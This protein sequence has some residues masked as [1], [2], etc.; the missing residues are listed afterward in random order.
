MLHEVIL[1]GREEGLGDL[2]I[3]DGEG[4]CTREGGS[5]IVSAET[6]IVRGGAS[7][8]FVW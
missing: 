3:R 8:A 7:G 6:S 5:D 4:T 2:Q 1:A